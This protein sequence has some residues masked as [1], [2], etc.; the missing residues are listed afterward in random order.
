MITREA[1]ALE[2]LV[3]EIPG[4]LRR[5]QPVDVDALQTVDQANPLHRRA[6]GLAEAVDCDRV[7]FLFRRTDCQAPRCVF[8][9]TGH[10]GITS[11]MLLMTASAKA[12]VATLVAPSIWRAKS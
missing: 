1:F 2:E 6:Q 9:K 8:K 10:G 4:Q 12:E 11:Y 5:R 3:L 7:A